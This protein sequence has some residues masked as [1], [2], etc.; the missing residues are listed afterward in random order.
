[1]LDAFI[2]PSV[3]L[4]LGLFALGVFRAPLI[5]LI[6]RAT[7]AGRDGI[8]FERPQDGTEVKPVPLSFIEIMKLPISSSALA[9]EQTIEKE[10]QASGLKGDGEKI[11]VLTRVL[12][13]TR[14]E[15]EFDG[16]AHS[17]FGSQVELLIKLVGTKNGITRQEAEEIFE[18][19]KTTFPELHSGRK[20]D[21]WLM[22]VQ[23]SNLITASESKI[24]ITQFGANFLKHLVD[25]RIAHARYG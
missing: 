9:R 3:V 10:L 12:A 18:H 1:M 16:V 24:D 15:R 21:D 7:K 25:S 2:W 14:V 11:S 4:I 17:I 5:R 19:A 13:A 6:D 20:L 23:S 8:S 22:Y